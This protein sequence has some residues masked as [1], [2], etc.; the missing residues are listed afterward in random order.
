MSQASRVCLVFPFLGHLSQT[1]IEEQKF[2]GDLLQTG[3]ALTGER[4]HR[5]TNVGRGA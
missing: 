4:V 2:T 5:L 3:D 1:R